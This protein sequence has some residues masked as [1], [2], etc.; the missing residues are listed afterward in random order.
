MAL[1]HKSQPVSS[2]P[3]SYRNAYRCNHL[4]QLIPS[5]PRLAITPVDAITITATSSLTQLE[6]TPVSIVTTATSSSSSTDIMSLTR[7]LPH[8]CC[9]SSM[10]AY[11]GLDMAKERGLD[12]GSVAEYEA[13]KMK[14]N[15]FVNE[16]Y[17]RF[18]LIINGLKLLGKVYPQNKM[19]KKVLQFLPKRWEAKVTTIHEAKVLQSLPKSWWD[20]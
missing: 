1:R 19:V 5:P 2:P 10:P 6:V 12:L 18:T 13:F 15:K 16:L 20:L 9:Q 17:S 4:H 3:S 8:Y 11:G 14:A 7:R